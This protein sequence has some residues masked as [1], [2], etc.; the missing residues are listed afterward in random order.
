MS[1]VVVDVVL[2]EILLGHLA[3]FFFIPFGPFEVVG[4][5]GGLFTSTVRTRTLGLVLMYVYFMGGNGA[6]IGFILRVLCGVCCSD[7]LSIE[8]VSPVFPSLIFPS[9]F[10]T[11]SNQGGRSFFPFP[12]FFCFDSVRRTI[13]SITM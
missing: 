1:F 10:F 2:N 7:T 6:W 11:F 8:S 12:F 9:F 5:F 13:R 3:S 4:A